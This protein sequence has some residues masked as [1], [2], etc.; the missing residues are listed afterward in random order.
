MKINKQDFGKDFV[1][2]IAS[3]AYQIEGAY[4]EDG[5]KWSI[6]DD[7]TNRKKRAKNRATANEATDFYHQYPEDLALMS[8]LGIRH[9]RY[10]LSWPRIIPDG[11][12]PVNH[13]GLDYYKRVVDTCL[14]YGIT[15]WLT[16]YHWDLP[17]ALEKQGGWTNRN[18]IGW[19]SDYARTC[20]AALGDRVKY[21]MIMNEP[22]VFIG[23]GYGVGLHAPGKR[24]FKHLLPALHHALLTQAEAA[25]LI[26]S[27]LPE[28]MVGTTFSIT[29]VDPLYETEKHRK[30]SERVS[31]LVNHLWLSPLLGYNY[32][33]RELPFLHKLER[34]TKPGD[35]DKMKFDMDFIGIQPY[36]REVVKHAFYIP[37]IKA[38]RV[39]AK[40]RK[41]QL[42]AMDW[43]FYPKAVYRAL[44]LLKSYE[45]LPAIYITENGLALNDKMT[46]NHIEDGKRIYY[47]RQ[48]LEHLY[49]AVRE[50][51]PVK[52]YFLWTFTD[53]FEWAE[54]YAPRF[55]IVHVDFA[56]Q[57]RTVKASGYWYRDF[58]TGQSG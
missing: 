21:W 53:N 4:L 11:Q 8:E 7:F 38:Y 20:V 5:R 22:N 31:T 19:F 46:N 16:L 23:A 43:E 32:P 9:F 45:N 33:V 42:T 26:K 3:S 34:Y 52:G 27:I 28:S 47:I 57:K 1:W 24:G 17:L 10:S 56:N 36:T 58:L 12:G 18:V 6:W 15:P 2:G 41:V 50:G 14:E 48:S 37:Y 44:K 54:G 25:K 29:P 35:E 51:S 49:R 40:K 30:A 55:G 13:K 39:T